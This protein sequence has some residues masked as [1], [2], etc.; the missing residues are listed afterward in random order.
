MTAALDDVARYWLDDM[1]VD[2]FRLDAAKHLI[3]DGSSS[4]TRPRPMPG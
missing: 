3:E 1:G 4:R 2:G